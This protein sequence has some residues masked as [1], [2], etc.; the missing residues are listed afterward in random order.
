[1]TS[2]YSLHFSY[3][4]HARA[5]RETSL[6]LE[7]FTR[8]YGRL[9]MIAK[10]ARQA[11]S[12]L[13]H[14]LV[15][16]RPLHIAWV[17]KSDL[18]TLVQAEEVVEQGPALAGI[19]IYCGLYINELLIRLLH[20]DDAHAELFY[21][22]QWALSALAKADSIE[23][24]LRIFEKRLLEHIGYGLNLCL[25]SPSG[26]FV[27]ADKQYTYEI[28]NGPIA[29][30]AST[31]EANLI[32]GKSLLDLANEDLQDSKSMKECKILMRQVLMH[33]LGGRPLK[34]RELLVNHF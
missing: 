25:E 12:R 6:L 9:N 22:Y 11:K 30:T 26:D 17:G 13:K 16:F 29:V 34:S 28:E 24:S 7:V 8:E 14:I 23:A 18:L 5:Y 20:K 10:G 27:Q 31:K 32:S 33:Y 1:M 15:P 4:L 3:L 2:R 19:S 21:D